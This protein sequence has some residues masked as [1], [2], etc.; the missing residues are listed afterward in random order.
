MGRNSVRF[1][2]SFMHVLIVSCTVHIAA[3]MHRDVLFKAVICK[4]RS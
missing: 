4:M 2:K 3:G 1:Q